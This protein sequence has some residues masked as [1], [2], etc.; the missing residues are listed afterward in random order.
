MIFLSLFLLLPL[1]V[2]ASVTTDMLEK[3]FDREQSEK[4]TGF[5]K[6][7]LSKIDGENYSHHTAYQKLGVVLDEVMSRF[8]MILDRMHLKNDDLIKIGFFDKHDA[9]GCKKYLLIQ[10]VNEKASVELSVPVLLSS[11]RAENAINPFVRQTFHLLK[12][13]LRSGTASLFDIAL[14]VVIFEKNVDYEAKKHYVGADVIH[15]RFVLGGNKKFVY[16]DFVNALTY[17]DD[18]LYGRLEGFARLFLVSS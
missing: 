3:A 12:E 4:L 17:K 16:E 5:L 9:H 1:S 13:S 6:P 14:M 2:Q 10:E 11:E 18:S 7:I 8:K 15:R